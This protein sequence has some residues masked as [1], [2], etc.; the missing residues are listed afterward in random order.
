[1]NKYHGK[2]CNFL[3]KL[4]VGLSNCMTLISCIT[5][6]FEG[7]NGWK[8]KHVMKWITNVPKLCKNQY[9]VALGEL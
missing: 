2:I 1:M 7:K 6:N 3:K 5:N 8:N 9:S 4:S